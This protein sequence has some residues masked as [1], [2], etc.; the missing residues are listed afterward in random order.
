MHPTLSHWQ[1]GLERITGA[2]NPLKEISQLSSSESGSTSSCLATA[3]CSLACIA[4]ARAACFL[5]NSSSSVATYALFFCHGAD[6]SSQW[7]E[8]MSCQQS[9]PSPQNATGVDFPQTH[10]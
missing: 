8:K 9:T 3:S 7:R 6:M 4:R 5:R 2:A 1:D 10:D